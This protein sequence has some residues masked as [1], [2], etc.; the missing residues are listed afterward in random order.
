MSVAGRLN[1]AQE[2]TWER[3]QGSRGHTDEPVLCLAFGAIGDTV[4]QVRGMRASWRPTH[5]LLLL[6]FCGPAAPAGTLSPTC[7]MRARMWPRCV[8]V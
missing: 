5:S 3:E 1:D 6:T 8:L 2:H 4:V 7:L